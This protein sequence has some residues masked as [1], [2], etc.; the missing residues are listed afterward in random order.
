[1]VLLCI[2]FQKMFSFGHTQV[3]GIIYF[4]KDKMWM[5]FVLWEKCNLEF[6]YEI[7]SFFRFIFQCCSVIKRKRY[8]EGPGT[9]R[10]K[11]YLN[12]LNKKKALFQPVLILSLY[13]SNHRLVIWKIW[14]S[15][16]P[17]KKGFLI[18]V[19]ILSWPGFLYF[20]KG[21][22]CYVN[23][24]FSSLFLVISDKWKCLSANN[25]LQDW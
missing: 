15:L 3:L 2:F 22:Y 21:L 4:N 8:W 13:H 16:E 1:M 25:Y 14:S 23:G 19:V 12:R 17:H 9:V 11:T 20:L 5:N 6:F 18:Y 7:L 10:N 24:R